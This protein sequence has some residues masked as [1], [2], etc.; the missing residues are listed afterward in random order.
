MTVIITSQELESTINK[1]KWAKQKAE[2]IETMRQ[3]LADLCGEYVSDVSD[4]TEDIKSHIGAISGF[5][6]IKPFFTADLNVLCN[7]NN[8]DDIK[9]KFSFS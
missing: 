8:T 5:K 1:I 4:I 2:R 3:A 7:D 6:S 9:K